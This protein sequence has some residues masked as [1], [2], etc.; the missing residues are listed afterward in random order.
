MEW[1]RRN[2]NGSYLI[3]G[4]C[5]TDGSLPSD[6]LSKRTFDSVT[7]PSLLKSR[8]LTSADVKWN[9]TY[10]ESFYRFSRTYKGGGKSCTVYR[11]G[12]FGDARAVTARAK[13]VEKYQLS[14]IAAW[15]IG[16]EDPAQWNMLRS[17]AGGI[18]P[19]ATS[20][21]AKAP[22][23]VTYGQD[24]R[25]TVTVRSQGVALDGAPVR[26]RL[27]PQRL[28]LVADARDR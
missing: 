19:T 5:P 15:T 11:E 17:L 12:W 6:Y 22:G 13:L 8:G 10:K 1:V 3:T 18:A 2:K 24:G 14:G 16:G 21:T 9:D 28:V 23:A 7:V 20:V 27:A 4:T 25:V 26:L